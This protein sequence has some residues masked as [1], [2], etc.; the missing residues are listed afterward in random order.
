MGSAAGDLFALL[1]VVYVIECFRWVAR[2]A[3]VFRDVP[4]LAPWASGALR[5]G[6]QLRRGLAFGWPLPPLGSMFAADGLLVQPGPRGVRLAPLD[7]PRGQTP[8]AGEPWLTW[9]D[10]S[11]LSV[12]GVELCRGQA[13][14]R[15]FGSRR[16]AR[17]CL[18]GLQA[19]AALPEAARPKAIARA[20]AGRLDVASASARLAPW[21]RWRRAV[22]LA[23]SVLFSA[24]FG[25]WGALAFAERPWPFWR[26]VV[27]MLTAWLM[28]AVTTVVAA[29]AVLPSGARPTR[30]QWLL[31]VLSPLSLIRSPD[32]IEPELVGDLEPAALAVAVLP[33]QAARDW[34]D[35]A[36]RELRH[37]VT[38]PAATPAAEP[39]LTDDAWWRA[40]VSA[41]LAQLAAGLAQTR[42]ALGAGLHCP[43][44][45]TSYGGDTQACSSCLGVALVRAA[46]DATA[47]SEPR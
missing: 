9:A 5:V 34:L 25:A 21:R 27:V 31:T 36:T 26:L 32:I 37:P 40:E 45:L 1:V 42:P 29:R 38:S 15:A 35:T 33:A 7:A 17:A 4:P 24:L 19:W 18:E 10:V 12:R 39:V 13:V 6:A 28:A 14:L 22:L 23:N 11:S 41:Q 30:G 8:L 43:R 44:C 20:L 16:A 2:D 3:V 47:G 46:V